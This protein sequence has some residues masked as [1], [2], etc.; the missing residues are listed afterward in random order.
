M[1]SNTGVK[2]TSPTRPYFL[3]IFTMSLAVNENTLIFRLTGKY[4]SARC[5]TLSFAASL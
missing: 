1:E 5:K 4:L 2:I 3:L